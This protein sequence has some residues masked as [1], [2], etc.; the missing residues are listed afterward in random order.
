MF[1]AHFIWSRQRNME[2]TRKN[3]VCWKEYFSQ[4]RD[5]FV[6]VYNRKQMFSLYLYSFHWILC[7]FFNNLSILHVL[8]D[9]LYPPKSCVRWLVLSHL[10]DCIVVLKTNI[11]LLIRTQKQTKK[12]EKRGFAKKNNKV[13]KWEKGIMNVNEPLG[14]LGLFV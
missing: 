3:V 8:S 6:C 2:G 14:S 9:N 7:A 5:A 10:D 12:K 4:K 13:I 11:K 1:G